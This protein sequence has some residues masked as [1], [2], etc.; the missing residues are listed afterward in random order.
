MQI[1]IFKKIIKKDLFVW[2]CIL[3]IYLNFSYIGTKRKYMYMYLR[4]KF[5]VNTWF[6][7]SFFSRV[8]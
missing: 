8:I 7:L 4:F 2:F 6:S 5:Y 3:D 1:H